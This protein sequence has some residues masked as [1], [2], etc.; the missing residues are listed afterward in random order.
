MASILLVRVVGSD[1]TCT[2]SVHQ[3]FTL[4]PL[5]PLPSTC[6]SFVCRPPAGN[7]GR[8]LRRI[9]EHGGAPRRQTAVDLV[10]PEEL[11]SHAHVPK[12]ASVRC[13][14]ESERAVH[15]AVDRKQSVPLHHR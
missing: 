5:S 13:A 14:V 9:E 1:V 3:C 6:I 11:R 7:V 8:A 10:Q 2:Y 12:G 15:T 4:P